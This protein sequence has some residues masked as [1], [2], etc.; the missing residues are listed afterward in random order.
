MVND[1]MVNGFME[2]KQYMSP[3]VEAQV[4]ESAIS[5]MRT[6]VELLND[7]GQNS[8]PKLVPKLGND[9]VSVF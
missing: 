7:P 9:S 6:S 2:K 8:A 5:I 1:K 4:M 3:L